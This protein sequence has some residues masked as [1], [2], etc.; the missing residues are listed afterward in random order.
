LTAEETLSTLLRIQDYTQK[1]DLMSTLEYVNR[2]LG[3]H[4]GRR[5]KEAIFGNR[6]VMVKAKDESVHWFFLGKT[7]TY[8]II[9]KTFCSCVDFEI[10]VV[11]RE[12]VPT[13]Y[14]LVAQVVAE[15]HGRYRCV[16]NL[17]VDEILRIYDEI[18][19]RQLS[20]T[21]HK[22]LLLRR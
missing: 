14:H 12:K 3:T 2:V 7:R 17:P 22:Y 4:R 13:C 15:V 5:V 10:N 16:S 6:V 11:E 1:H 8:I 20:T 19:K 21:L 18:E 9:P